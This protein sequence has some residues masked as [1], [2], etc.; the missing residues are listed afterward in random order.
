VS[1]GSRSAFVVANDSYADKKLRK[2]RAPAA[3]AEQL[4]KVLKDAEIGGFDVQVSMNEPEHVVRRKLSAFFE[5]RGL[6]DLLVLHLSCHGVK[7][8]D[9][10]LYF[11][12][13]DTEV[14]HLEATAIPSEFVNR[15][16]TRSRSRRIVLLLDCCYSG[17]FATGFMSRAGDRVDIKDRFDGRGRIV[18]TASS[19]M[20]YSFEGNELEGEGK[21]SFFTSALVRGLATG[22]A[23]RDRDGWIS[24]DELYDY[25][26]DEVRATTPSQTPGKWVFDVQGDLYVAR[27][28][29]EPEIE[30]ATLP[31]GLLAAVKSPFA[32]VR[33]GAVQELASL[34][35]GP[36]EG[37]AAAA[38]DALEQLREDDSQRV[39][40][41]AAHALGEGPAEDPATRVRLAPLVPPA[42]RPVPEPAPPDSVPKLALAGA[43]ALLAAVPIPI[44][45]SAYEG[46]NTF[47][48][49]P[50]FETLALALAAGLVARAVKSRGVATSFAAGVFVAIGVLGAAASLGLLKFTHERLSTFATL[51]AV[52]VLLGSLGILAAGVASLRASAGAHAAGPLDPRPLLIGV[53]GTGL[54]I[55]SLFLYYDG[56]SSLWSEVGDWGSG[57]FLF[58]PVAAIVLIVIGLV[59]LSSRPRFASALLVVVGGATVLHFIGLIVA[60][61]RAVGEVGEVRS[62]GFVG[63]L[64]GLVVLLA[65]ADA[66]RSTKQEAPAAPV[67]EPT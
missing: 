53:V 36:D 12:T 44:L 35:D 52:V 23:D 26:Y 18:L 25:A 47:A 13:A 27:S 51:L 63:A 33:A 7:D 19:A 2:L 48:V 1:E 31:L 17:A 14:D 10:R 49:Q 5:N 4:A 21:P 59:V 34:L 6:D 61:W 40:A 60:A 45:A 24:V 43:V 65:G 62:G 28:K 50:V 55:W 20:E 30:E 46:W 41:A 29:L 3:D 57:E 11:A 32:H 64:G 8:D 22:E 42:P 67:A 38:R 15:Q 56:Y 9:G 54:T 58:E 39:V 37:V 66:Y 16:M